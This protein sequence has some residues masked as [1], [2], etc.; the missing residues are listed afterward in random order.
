MAKRPYF[1]SFRPS[2][3]SASTTSA[4]V[5]RVVALL[6]EELRHDT[7][8]VSALGRQTIVHGLLDVL[9]TQIMRE[10]MRTTAAGAGWSHGVRDAGVRRA[11]ARLHDDCARPWTLEMLAHEV[12]M[13]R[14]VLAERFR[15]AVGTPPLAYLRTVRL[16]KAM[17]LLSDGDATLERVAAAVG[18]Q[19]AFGFSKAF[20]R[21]VGLSPGEFRRQDAVERELPWRFS[22]REAGAVHVG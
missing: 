19:D 5:A 10:V 7:D 20:K 3:G 11:L 14:S 8:D 16:Q 12:G 22:G 9:F 4:P 1:L 15:D 13:S 17:R 21:A 18:Y 2:L 6:T